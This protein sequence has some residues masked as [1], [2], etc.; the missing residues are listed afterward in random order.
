MATCRIAQRL[1]RAAGAREK[2]PGQPAPLFGACDC[3]LGAKQTVECVPGDGSAT[4]TLSEALT[5]GSHTL[6]ATIEDVTARLG[7]DPAQAQSLIDFGGN[8]ENMLV[9]LL[10]MPLGVTPD[11]AQQPGAVPQQL[12][13]TPLNDEQL[14]DVLA[15][16]SVN[17]TTDTSLE[18]RVI[19]RSV[20][21][22][23]SD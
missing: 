2:A 22:A 10:T 12:P 15:E 18:K 3:T 13:I 7:V 19:A 17:R 1:G 11:A 4:C 20:M 21:R 14:R 23:P 8:P 9:Q 5:D 6:T 16:T